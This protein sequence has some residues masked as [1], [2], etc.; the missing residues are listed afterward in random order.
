MAQK[1]TIFAAISLTDAFNELIADFEK[2]NPAVKIVAEYAG[3]DSLPRKI[4]DGADADIFAS[5]D[6]EAMTKAAGDRVLKPGTEKI[7]ARNALVIVVPKGGKKPANLKDIENFE[8]IAIGLP[9]SVPAGRY[10]KAALKAAGL[11]DS[12]ASRLIRETNV[13]LVLQSVE[14]G[15]VD[16]GFVY[17][18]DALAANDTVEIAMTVE[19]PG[20]V[21]YPFAVTEKGDAALAE[22]FMNFVLSPRG[23]DILAKYGFVKP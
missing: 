16:A 12:L 6:R 8:R 19:G 17:K 15:E 7:F 23:Q 14:R 3:T 10:A 4:A 18:T 20:E 9:D 11:W 5:A 21:E 22:K 1:L 13:R 2:E